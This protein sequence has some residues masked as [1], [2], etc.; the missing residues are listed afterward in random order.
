MFLS[1]VE[2]YKVSRHPVKRNGCLLTGQKPPW[3]IERNVGGRSRLMHRKGA[4]RS[5]AV[6]IVLP[7]DRH[8]CTSMHA[9]TKILTDQGPACSVCPVDA[10]ST[11]DVTS[12]VSEAAIADQTRIAGILRGRGVRLRGCTW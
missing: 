2:K 9:K 8:Y 1:L 12:R 6:L 10:V 5:W 11:E 4:C 3:R 7:V